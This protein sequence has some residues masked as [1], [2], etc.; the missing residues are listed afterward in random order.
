MKQ[1]LTRPTESNASVG[2]HLVSNRLLASLQPR[3]RA[4]LD[5]YLEAVT[6]YQG[7]VLFEPGDDVTRTYF[8]CAST[9]A[10]FVVVMQSGRA[11][12]AATVGREG[13]LGGIVSSG[14]KPAF[15][16]AEVQIPGP[17]LRIETS[18]L[19]DAKERSATLRD[20]FSRYADALLAQIIQSV[21]CNA[22]HSLEARCCRWLLTTQDRVNSAE[23]PLTQE[24]LAEMLGVQRTTVTSVA[25]AL[26]AR[27][28]IRYARG[29][30]VILDRARLEGAACECHSAVKQ[31]FDRVLP[32][33]KPQSILIAPDG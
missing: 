27:G 25:R 18:R 32:E 17:A 2:H 30:I 14:Y 28:L 1:P 12:E 6:L 26:R 7:E 22:L 16:R 19:E 33:V 11:A 20:L 8:P 9:M 5:P 29:Q 31:H 3:D 23:I 13:A 4:L 15:T 10:S 21:A 24:A